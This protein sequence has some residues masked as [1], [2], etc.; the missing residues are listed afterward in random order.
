MTAVGRCGC[1]RLSKFEVAHSRK[2]L[3]QVV[4]AVQQST[5]AQNTPLGR[6]NKHIC[7]GDRCFAVDGLS[8]KA[9]NGSGR[10]IAA[11]EWGELL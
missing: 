5:F 8:R 7:I 4:N 1:R 10:M 9:R 2:A 6:I 11:A 3:M